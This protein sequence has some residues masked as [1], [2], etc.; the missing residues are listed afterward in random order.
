MSKYFKNWRILL[1]ILFMVGVAN[2]WPVNYARAASAREEI[3]ASAAQVA[4]EKWS[5]YP[6]D[7]KEYLCICQNKSA[8]RTACLTIKAA[9][10]EATESLD[11]SALLERQSNEVCAKFATNPQLE[12]NGDF[13]TVMMFASAYSIAYSNSPGEAGSSPY[14]IAEVAKIEESNLLNGERLTK[15]ESCTGGG[16]DVA[17]CK[18][19]SATILAQMMQ[20]ALPPPPLLPE[21]PVL[22]TTLPGLTLSDVTNIEGG[23]LYIPWIAEYVAAL[24]RYGVTVASILAVVLI[25][26]QGIK[27]IISGGGEQKMEAYKTIGRVVIGL[28][29]AWSAYAILYTINPNLVKLKT[30]PIDVILPTLADQEI[31]KYGMD[32]GSNPAV[33]LS[34]TCLTDY[35]KAVNLKLLHLNNITINASVPYLLKPAADAVVKLDGIIGR[36]KITLN[37]PDLRLAINGAARTLAQQTAFRTDAEKRF[38]DNAKFQASTSDCHNRGHLTGESID[39]TIENSYINDDKWRNSKDDK[40]GYAMRDNSEITLLETMVIEAGFTRYCGEWWHY[41]FFTSNAGCRTR[42]PGWCP[43]N[44]WTGK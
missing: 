11:P 1:A 22:E 36:M 20:G 43:C 26:L 15:F 23:M 28:V 41:E 18:S 30:L 5:G 31:M 2:C 14:G 12:K 38:G 16:D 4:A 32:D 42:T 17:T 40:Y 19:D 34:A 39:I 3:T 13:L 35:S 27:I 6:K 9:E 8:L 44:S 29:I 7:L 37:R 21:K 24:F 33:D 10:P 25:I